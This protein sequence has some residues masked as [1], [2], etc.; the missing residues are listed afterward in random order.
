MHL[1]LP[2]W[3][4]LFILAS[5]VC[6]SFQC[7]IFAQGG[8]MVVTFFRL[9]CSVMWGGRNTANKY[10]WH[11]GGVLTVFQLHWVCPHYGVCAF[12]VYTAQALGC[13]ARNCLMRA[14]GCMHS[15]QAA[16]VQVLGYSTKVQA[17]LGLCFLPIPGASSSGDQVI[18]KR[19]HP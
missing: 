9:T 5:S 2:K 14:L 8:A 10:H 3:F 18:G 4:P 7:L 17:W 15:P 12:P 11:V 16:Q 19:C 13:S 1:S 6:W